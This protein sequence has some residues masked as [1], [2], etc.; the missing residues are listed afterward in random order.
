MNTYEEEQGAFLWVFLESWNP[1]GSQKPEF[2]S[3]ELSFVSQR[4][5]FKEL[6][7]SIAQKNSSRLV[8][9]T[10]GESQGRSY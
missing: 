5:K 2:F 3:H 1:A 9:G 6:V 4:K 8:Q 7:V 10:E